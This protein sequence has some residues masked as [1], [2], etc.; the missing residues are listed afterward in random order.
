MNQVRTA[1]IAAA[2]TVGV[3]GLGS[4]LLKPAVVPAPVQPANLLAGM[5]ASDAAEYRAFFGA[6][7][8][9]VERDGKS[10]QPVLTTT[11]DLRN[12][13]RQAL[14]LAFENTGLVGRYPGFGARLDEYELRAIGAADNQLTTEERTKAAN[15]FRAIR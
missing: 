11:F 15:A 5:S 12:R 14:K 2:L 13:Y 3:L 4:K 9:M 10:T 1:I 8:E 7:A 6:V